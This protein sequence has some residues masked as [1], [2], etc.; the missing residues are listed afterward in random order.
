MFIGSSSG[1]RF[2]RRLPIDGEYT[3][4]VYLMQAAARRH[5]SS[6]FSLEVR[7][8]GQPLPPLSARQDALIAGTPFHASANIACTVDIRQAPASCKAFVIR[9]RLDGT[10]TVEVRWQE[11]TLQNTARILFVKGRPVSSDAIG[12]LSHARQ[13]DVTRVRLGSGASFEVPDALVSGG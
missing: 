7:L 4:R 8:T 10:A 2:S 5:E 6:R 11:G 13:G 12:P 9:R 3:I 1:T